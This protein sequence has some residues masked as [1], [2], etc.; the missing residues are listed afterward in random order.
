[1]NDEEAQSFRALG[2]P[3]RWVILRHLAATPGEVGA[4]EFADVVSV[5][6]PTLSYHLAV[7][8]EAGLIE[9]RKEGRQHFHR[10]RP[11]AVAHVAEFLEA[12][13]LKGSG[14]DEQTTA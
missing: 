1:M 4:S 8:R 9:Q 11:E 7:L 12:G 14:V 5:G 10:I 6:Q 13:L 2:D 3:V